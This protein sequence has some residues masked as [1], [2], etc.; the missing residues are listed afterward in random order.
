MASQLPPLISR[1]FKSHRRAKLYHRRQRNVVLKLLG[2]MAQVS[3]S[4]FALL[5]ITQDGA[6]ET[7]TSQALSMLSD[8]LFSF[9]AIERA[10]ERVARFQEEHNDNSSGVAQSTADVYGPRSIVALEDAIDDEI[11]FE[12]DSEDDMDETHMSQQLNI[13]Q[14]PTAAPT[15][16]NDSGPA[17]LF[18]LQQPTPTRP[19]NT[20]ASIALASP[21]VD[22]TTATEAASSSSSL[23]SES[24]DTAS[25]SLVATAVGPDGRVLVRHSF[26]PSTLASWYEERFNQ[27]PQKTSKIILRTIIRELEPM[28]VNH[29]PYTGGQDS[30]P[31]W[32]PDGVR[33]KEPDHLLKQGEL[34]LVPRSNLHRSSLPTERI[35]LLDTLLR[36]MNVS[37]E[38]FETFEDAVTRVSIMLPPRLL[39]VIDNI[40]TV[41]KE[42]RRIARETGEECHRA[43]TAGKLTLTL[44]PPQVARWRAW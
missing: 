23:S 34:P 37:P 21:L 29:W 42:E 31:P 6:V 14:Q 19:A 30:K 7:L 13:P 40:F 16:P 8:D 28:K 43:F 2:N 36:R 44:L 26:T 27:L 24:P 35:T 33:H 12:A 41:V 32:W 11:D 17:Q 5:W 18:V 10:K 20:A 38:R 4:H 1:P 9:N 22:P 3:N 39:S 15:R 25:P